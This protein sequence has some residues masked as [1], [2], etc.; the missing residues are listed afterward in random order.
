ME[1]AGFSISAR[2]CTRKNEN[3]A[4]YIRQRYGQHPLPR[5]LNGYTV[6]SFNMHNFQAEL[7]CI[8]EVSND[9]FSA[10]WHFLP[11]S[12]EEY[13]FSAKFMRLVTCPEQVQIVEHHGQPVGVLQCVWD[14][15]PLL[16][17]LNGSVGP[18]KYL[19]FLS[20]RKRIRTLIIYAVGIRRAYQRTPVYQLL[21]N[22]LCEMALKYD[23]LETTWL[24][25]LNLLAARAAERFGL[26]PDKEFAIYEKRITN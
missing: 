14:I 17:K 22:A 16:R 18:V 6:R 20:R 24:S 4:E 23:V 5:Q 3:I 8:R 7:E 9:A 2:L 13:L 11:L 12:R 1:G 26:K 19:R 25:P 21:M 10:N 15:N